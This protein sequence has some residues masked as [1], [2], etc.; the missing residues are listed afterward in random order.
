MRLSALN[1]VLE[2]IEDRDVHK[3]VNLGDILSGAL[4]PRETADRLMP[5]GLPTIAG[6]HECQVL[7][8]DPAT[9]GPSDRH[10]LTTL[11]ADQIQWIAS[12]P[13]TLRLRKNV[14]LVHGIPSSNLV[15]YLETVGNQGVRP[16][17]MREIQER[18]GSA[19]EQLILCG[20]SH[21][22]RIAQL[23][24]GRLVVNPGSVG[25][26]AYTSDYPSPHAMETGTPHARYAILEQRGFSW[27]AEF[28]AVPYDWQQA[29]LQAEANGRPDWARAL[30][31]GRV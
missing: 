9:M 31:T 4:F 14:L 6:N 13:A 27:L 8:D 1:A 21:I 22:P 15:Y 16:A 20:H 11:R 19:D 30:R 7:H 3:I 26:Q 25:L 18:S 12:L 29:S 5:L 24:D 28:L 10:A 23:D 17:T 2:D